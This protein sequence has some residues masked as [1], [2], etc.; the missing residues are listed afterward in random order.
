MLSMVSFFVG[1][2]VGSSDE[3]V[4]FNKVIRSNPIRQYAANMKSYVF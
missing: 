4:R 3:K 2:R 1:V